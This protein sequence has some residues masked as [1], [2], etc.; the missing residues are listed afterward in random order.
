MSV[1][2][3]GGAFYARLTIMANTFKVSKLATGLF[4]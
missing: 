4:I 3:V 2:P 1:I